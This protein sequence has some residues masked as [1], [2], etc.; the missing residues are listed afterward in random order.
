[1]DIGRVLL[2]WE[3]KDQKRDLDAVKI[4]IAFVVIVL[5]AAWAFFSKQWLTGGTF[6]GAVLVLSWYLAM[7]QKNIAISIT[8][9]G[10]IIDGSFYSFSG[11]KNYWVS[12]EGVA[13]FVSQS[14][15]ASIISLPLGE[16]PADKIFS[17]IPKNIVKTESQNADLADKV[18]RLLHK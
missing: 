12:R 17:L 15:L 8:D 18:A 5:A 2:S 1:M 7:G 13:Y 4:I 11:L 10:L 6:I 9:K 3:T 16:T 14:K